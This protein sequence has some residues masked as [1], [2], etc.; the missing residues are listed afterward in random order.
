MKRARP[1]SRHARFRAV[2]THRQSGGFSLLAAFV[3]ILV[4][5]FVAIS[6]DTGRLWLERRHIQKV[7]DMAAMASVHFTGCGGSLKA[8]QDAALRSALDNGVDQVDINGGKVAISATHGFLVREN[9][10][11]IYRPV[12]DNRDG[13][14][15]A[16]ITV[17]KKVPKSLVLGGLLTD[18]MTLYAT[19]TAK[20]G[21]P[22]A[23][24]SMDGSM[25]TIDTPFTRGLNNL[26][27]SVFKR[28]LNLGAS[29]FNQLA[30]ASVSLEDLRK[31]GGFAS[32]DEMLN[33]DKSI[34]WLLETYSQ[35]AAEGNAE[36]SAALSQL[37]RAVGPSNIGL[38]LGD[39]LKLNPGD[40]DA[41][42]DA[43][44]NLLE[45]VKVSVSVAGKNAPYDLDLKTDVAGVGMQMQIDDVPQI[46]VGPGGKSSETGQW[47]TQSKT[48]QATLSFSIGNG[49]M[50]QIINL[51]TFG[52][53]KAD[54]KFKLIFGS[55]EARLNYIEPT[56]SAAKVQYSV[57]TNP[58]TM[59]VTNNA[60]NDN[61]FIGIKVGTAK[62]GIS[63]G[64]YG[65]A[66]KKNEAN[67]LV[68]DPL[69]PLPT[70]IQRRLIPGS[71]EMQGALAG[72]LNAIPVPQ[73]ELGVPLL[74]ALFG[75][76]IKSLLQPVMDVIMGIVGQ[77][78]ATTIDPVLR[79]IGIHFGSADVMLYD[80]RTVPPELVSVKTAP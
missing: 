2:R 10:D 3:M 11:W 22:I 79:A 38:K 7:A 39:V 24:Y 23:T 35:A 8:V 70:P 32:V 46:A 71:S 43:E 48:A 53:A 14:R 5:G 59:S 4:F 45:L 50:Q 25:L 42:L 16:Q 69:T 47:C 44:I 31:A 19:A 12:S 58:F 21:P 17:T 80:L 78:L 20:G 60:E 49:A 61:G 40:K 54:I 28:P 65:N 62:F 33:S 34:S 26:L 72:I 55:A 66:V 76:L 18:D 51:L 68:P 73:P 30:S 1:S 77:L 36:G 15:A 75:N 52:A 67:V 6:L 27:E 56:V 74:S 57:N 41:L 29:V 64:N 13:V 9:G 63:M 37:I